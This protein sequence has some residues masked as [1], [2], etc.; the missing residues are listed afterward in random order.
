MKYLFSLLL[1][2]LLAACSSPAGRTVQKLGSAVKNCC[3]SLSFPKDGAPVSLRSGEVTGGRIAG[4]VFE[5]E[6]QLLHATW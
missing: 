3:I 5:P 1:I 4:S 6:I 2:V